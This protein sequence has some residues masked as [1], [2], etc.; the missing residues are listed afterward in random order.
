[1]MYRN[2]S[3]ALEKKI[4]SQADGQSG[5]ALPKIDPKLPAIENYMLLNEASGGTRRIAPLSPVA[6]RYVGFSERQLISLFWQ[7]PTL[8]DKIRCMMIEDGYF[9]DLTIVPAQSDALNWIAQIKM[10]PPGRII[11]TFLS[12]V[13][14]PHAK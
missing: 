14:L 9:Q 8:K 7:W 6:R 2:G 11:T 10:C 1:M 13:G 3:V 12:D 5:T 4:N